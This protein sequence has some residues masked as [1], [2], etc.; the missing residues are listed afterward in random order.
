LLVICGITLIVIG[1]IFGDAFAVF[2][3]HQNANRIGEALMA[4][5]D[6]VAAKDSVAVEGLFRNIGGLLE[7]RGTKVDAHVHVIGFGYLALLLALIQP[8]VAF[9]E[10]T[11]KRL[12]EVQPALCD[13]MGEHPG[14]PGRTARDR[15]LHRRADRF[16]AKAAWRWGEN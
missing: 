6:A 9:T 5:T 3:L 10:R 7:N 12:P 16:V 14:G 8:H 2:V 11:L 13:R 15:S 4:A 1:M